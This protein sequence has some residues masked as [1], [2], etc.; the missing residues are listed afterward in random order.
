MST[1][2]LLGLSYWLPGTSSPQSY[3]N[4]AVT[5]LDLF[6]ANTVKSRTTAAQPGSPAVGDAYIL[7]STPTGADW[8]SFD[9]G[10][11]VQAIKDATGTSITYWV[12]YAPVVG[13]PIVVQDSSEIVAWNGADYDVLGGGGG[14][15]SSGGDGVMQLGDGAG[16]FDHAGAATHNGNLECWRDDGGQADIT[17]TT[18]GVNGGG[19]M[20]GRSAN[21]TRSSP[22][23]IL[24]GEIFGGFG[25]R[26]YH[27]GGAFQTS[28][29]TSIHWV[30]SENQTGTSYG[31]YL[32]ILTTP[33][34]ETTRQERVIVADSGTLWCHG[35]GTFDPRVAAQTKPFADTTILASASGT[36]E[37]ASVSAVTYGTGTA[38]FRGGHAAGTAASPSATP[39]GRLL[40]FMGGHGHDGGGWTA[41]TK[42]L[43]GFYSAENWG[44]SANGTLMTFETTPL[45]STT[46]AEVMRLGPG[47]RIGGDFSNATPANRLMF[48]STTTNGATSLGALPNGSGT[49]SGFNF[50]GGSSITNIDH[51]QL[52]MVGGTEF[53]I[54]STK[55]G[56]GTARPMTFYID[57][58]EAARFDTSRNYLPGGNNTQTL[59]GASNRWSVVYAGTGTINTSDAREKTA[60][61]PLS[62]AEI[63]AATQLAREIGSFQF[64][65]AVA[66]KGD[67]ARHH[68]GLTVQ[69]AIEVLQ[70]HG[71]DP[72]RYAFICHDAWDEVHVPQSL[73][74]D[75]P[76][77]IKP[78]GDRF[79]F[80]V[81]QLL[82]FL[83][84]GFE[85]RLSRLE[86]A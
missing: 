1:S 34:G 64:L 43:I 39:T 27:S 53:R 77:H 4:D 13:F 18:Y 70:A 17:A 28:S 3:Q 52:V 80:R 84:R 26:A 62:D 86:G 22:T 82:L 50:F 37:S 85:S 5:R 38:G 49:N 6:A 8:G 47:L 7:P 35:A 11:I 69:R 16:G 20:H 83:V 60:V 68:I 75:A 41:G 67:D 40:T 55:Q 81:D 54:S 30:A 71:L 45:G 42:A 65:S 74:T 51:G 56:S 15:S 78:A 79:G 63:A 46:R 57:S 48:Q 9:E 19:I 58:T 33:K 12:R 66:V 32:R 23:A 25:C 14:G 73:E 2:P 29:P 59:G 21:G 10:D 24:S 76:A 44:G 72:F 31:S 61:V 36:G